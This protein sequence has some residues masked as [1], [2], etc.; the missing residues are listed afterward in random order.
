MRILV[1]ED[2]KK[3]AQFL[4]KGLIEAGYSVDW[5]ET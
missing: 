5:A 1:A 4:K 3:M 2:Q